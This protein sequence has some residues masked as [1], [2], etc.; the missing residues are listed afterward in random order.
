MCV[1]AYVRLT[2]IPISNDPAR[3][4]GQSDVGANR[5]WAHELCKA[6]RVASTTRFKFKWRR[7]LRDQPDLQLYA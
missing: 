7:Q 5:S 4:L 3:D 2:H 1:S 6:V